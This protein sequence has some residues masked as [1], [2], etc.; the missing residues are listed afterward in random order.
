MVPREK[1]IVP[2]LRT[3]RGF[4]REAATKVYLRI[5]DHDGEEIAKAASRAYAKLFGAEPP[6]IEPGT[7]HTNKA[8]LR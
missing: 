4:D 8:W 3:D 5:T 1:R 2:S 6:R 7:C